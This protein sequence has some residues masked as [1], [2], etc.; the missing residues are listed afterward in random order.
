MEELPN[1]FTW[2]LYKIVEK[3]Q[4]RDDQVLTYEAKVKELEEKLKQY[5]Q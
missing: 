2:E 4:E 5:E 3:L 1:Y